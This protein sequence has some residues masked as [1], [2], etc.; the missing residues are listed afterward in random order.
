MSESKRLYY[1]PR[2]APKKKAV[3][4]GAADLSAAIKKLQRR[5]AERSDY[6]AEIPA[7]ETAEQRRMREE[8][9]DKA[10]APIDN[11]R[12]AQAKRDEKALDKAAKE[13]QRDGIAE[14]RAMRAVID[15]LPAEFT[16]TR[17]ELARLPPEMQAVATAVAALD[18]ALGARLDAIAAQNPVL[19]RQLMDAQAVHQTT[20]QNLIR[21]LPQQTITQLQA[22]A[23]KAQQQGAPGTGTGT[24]QTAPPVLQTPP[25]GTGT[26]VPGAPPRAQA[27]TPP[28]PGTGTG[29]PATG[30]IPPI[31]SFSQAISGA[32]AVGSPTTPQIGTPSA[33]PQPAPQTGASSGQA[34]P[35]PAAALPMTPGAATLLNFLDHLESTGQ[36]S[37]AVAV[38]QKS[39]R[40]IDRIRQ[41]YRDYTKNPNAKMPPNPRGYVEQY[42]AGHPNSDIAS[43]LL[44]RPGASS[45]GKPAGKAVR[46]RGLEGGVIWNPPVGYKKGIVTPQQ[47]A[48][49]QKQRDAIAELRK[50][51]VLPKKGMGAV[52]GG[53]VVFEKHMLD[54]VKSRTSAQKMGALLGMHLM[55]HGL[56]KLTPEHAKAIHARL[57]EHIRGAGFGDWFFKGLA[58]PFQAIKK[59]ADVVPIPGISQVASAFGSSVPNLVSKLGVEPINF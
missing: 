44:P 45:G 54:K 25:P 55:N 59:V 56:T 20:L 37:L 39:G 26:G 24:G 58:L 49:F 23:P 52:A 43:A 48:E 40:D 3:K 9:Q 50:Q 18:P 14:T 12:R 47:E 33:P 13:A 1:T 22:L 57:P 27:Q 29:A 16:A 31:R 28:P 17:V 53:R 34:S 21:T 6:F 7:A 51:G 32:P 10:G 4:G 36:G 8:I 2:E 30:L 38:G 11:E 19:F 15:T 42:A 5:M 46:G 35:Q 41:L